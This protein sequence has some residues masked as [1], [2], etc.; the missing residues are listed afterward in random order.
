MIRSGA[1]IGL[2]IVLA[3]A[4][5]CH[6]GDAAADADVANGDDPLKALTVA[7]PST[8][9]TS[10]Y[11][12]TRASAADALW[13]KAVSYCEAQRSA[14]SGARPNCAAVY[15]AQFEI[16]GRAPVSTYQRRSATQMEAKP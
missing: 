5:A 2:V 4:T 11:W 7:T 13:P 1:V 16:A 9:Y 6:R 14:A 8:R 3:S 15:S 10:T 12:Q